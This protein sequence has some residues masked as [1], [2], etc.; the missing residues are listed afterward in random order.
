M[1]EAFEPRLLHPHIIDKFDL[2]SLHRGHGEDSFSDTGGQTARELAACGQGTV[3]LDHVE[4]GLLED[5][6]SEN[7]L[8]ANYC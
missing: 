6:K 4:L 3:F 2:D 1:E 8:N 7:E 5:A